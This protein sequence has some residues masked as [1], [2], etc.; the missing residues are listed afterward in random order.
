MNNYQQP[1]TEGH[2][3]QTVLIDQAITAETDEMDPSFYQ[4]GPPVDPEDEEEDDDDFPARED[5][6]D[7]DDDDF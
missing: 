2:D 7:D 1:Q 4:Q 3:Q 5:L 6:E